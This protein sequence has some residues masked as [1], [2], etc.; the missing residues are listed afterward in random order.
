MGGRLAAVVAGGHPPGVY[1]WRSRAHIR[2]VSRELAGAG[3]VGYALPHGVADAG[4]LFEEC[5]GMFAFPGWFGHTWEA[6]ADCLGDL[7]WLAGSGHVLVWER[8]GTLAYTDQK[9]WRLAYEVFQGAMAVRARSAAAPLYLLLR[10]VGPEHS[11]LDGKPIP[12]LPAASPAAS[13]SA[14]PP[15][16]GR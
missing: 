13:R 5:A 12:V 7:S 8:Y 14:S 16:R 1:R 3:W 2:A 4:R 11:P 9:S 15:F 10:G 6:L